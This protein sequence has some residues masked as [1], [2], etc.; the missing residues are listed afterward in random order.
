MTPGTFIKTKGARDGIGLRKIIED[1]GSEFLVDHYRWERV[2]ADESCGSRKVVISPR[3]K[4]KSN[5][6]VVRVPYS[7]L[8]MKN[9]VIRVYDI[10][11]DGF[12]CN[13]ERMKN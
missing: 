6:K 7:S 4:K 8:V 5:F 12:L 2:T 9:K 1:R 10:D 3:T 11:S 13:E